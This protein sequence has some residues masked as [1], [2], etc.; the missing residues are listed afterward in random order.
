MD[1]IKHDIKEGSTLESIAKEKAISVKELVDFHNSQVPMTQQIYG[2][3]IP[4]HIES[5]KISPLKIDKGDFNNAKI[6]EGT[7]ARY[8]CE[9]INISRINNE[10]ITLSATTYSEYLVKRNTNNK[11]HLHIDLTDSSFNVDPEIYKQGFNFALKLEKVRTPVSL[12]LNSSGLV[13]EIFEKEQLLQRWQQFRDNELKKEPLFIQLKNQAEAQADDLIKTGNKEF[14]SMT[15]F[16]K[17]LDKNLFFHILFRALQGS[18]LLDY[19]LIQLSQIFPNV[20]VKVHVVKSLVKED[21]GKITYRLVGTLNK[22]NI[23]THDLKKMY[24]EIYKPMI[25]YAFT[26][27]EYIYRI[28]YTIDKKS[29]LLLEGKAILSEKIKNNYEILTEYNIRQVEL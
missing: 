11:A 23:S 1:Y 8:R 16:A 7:S 28:R 22:E 26:E 12:E 19:D 18:N 3:Y 10:T 25:N 5:L 14:S 20:N 21:E 2:D 4:L 13:Q 29:G 24:D 6:E 9:Q 15:D 17:T 27:F